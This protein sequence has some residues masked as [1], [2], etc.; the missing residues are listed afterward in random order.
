MKTNL[1]Q[2]D[3]LLKKI[4]RFLI[5]LPLFV[6]LGACSGPPEVDN[7]GRGIEI[8]D[9]PGEVLSVLFQHWQDKADASK[10]YSAALSKEHM[11]KMAEL[12][13]KAKGYIM[14]EKG[15]EMYQEL[16]G[17]VLSLKDNQTAY[18]VY[19]PDGDI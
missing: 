19:S 2:D 15:Q 5:C 4:Y 16:K 1:G 7:T 13:L 8:K 6:T 3:I 9:K 17:E 12:F 14:T 18:I 10:L 11:D